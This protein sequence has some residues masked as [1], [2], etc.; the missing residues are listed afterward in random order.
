M[1]KI[2]SSSGYIQFTSN[3]GSLIAPKGLQLTIYSDLD[4]AVDI[5][6]R[7]STTSYCIVLGGF[8][9]LGTT[10]KQTFVTWFST[11]AE[12]KAL[13]STTTEKVWIC[14]LLFEL[15]RP[16]LK[17]TSLYCDNSAISLVH[18][19]VL[20]A[21]TKHIDAD[22]HSI[23]DYLKKDQIVLYPHKPLSNN[24]IQALGTKLMTPLIPQFEGEWQH[25]HPHD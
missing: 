22:Y 17:P 3:N 8:P 9:T 25:I 20:H 16:V 13:S 18:N 2:C 12:Y 4:W 24:R 21:K 23:R 5:R 10:K 6:N 15:S 1:Y 7:W 14:Q 19:P 11:E